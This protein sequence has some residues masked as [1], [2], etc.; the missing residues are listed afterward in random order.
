M[1]ATVAIGEGGGKRQRLA[2][3]FHAGGV[4]PGLQRM[5][6]LLRRDLRVLAYHRVLDLPEPD[7]FSFD[8]ALVSASPA[9]FR[10]QM[11]LVRRRFSPVRF[12][13]VAAALDGG[14]PLPRDPVVV[15]FDDGYDDNYRIAFPILR[16]L[17]VPATFF[18]STGHID[19][20]QPY[21]YDWLVHMICSTPARRIALPALGVDRTLPAALPERRDLA[22]ALLDRLKTLD[23]DA[24]TALIAGLEAEWNLPRRPHPDCRPMSWDQLREMQADGMEIGSHGVHHRMLAKLPRAEM[25]REVAESKRSL[26]HHLPLPVSVISYPVGGPD[27]YDAAVI[28]AVR[29]AGFRIACSYVAGTNPLPAPPRHALRRLPVEREMDAPWFSAMVTWPEVFGYPSRLRS[30]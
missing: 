17:G 6:G 20:G 19:D 25:E 9:Q 14:P 30:G 29:H 8:L 4:L 5:R 11:D 1:A 18:V 21:A 12:E 15:T 7:R 28:A 27:A 24:Q 10:R 3:W 23:D 13:D 22:A 26:D 16:E 2:R